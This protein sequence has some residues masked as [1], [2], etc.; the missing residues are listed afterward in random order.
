MHDLDWHRPDLD[1]F[2]R[3]SFLPP[4]RLLGAPRKPSA[5]SGFSFVQISDS[6]IGFNKP[7]NP[8]VTA[9]YWA[10][11]D[12]SMSDLKEFASLYRE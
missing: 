4:C 5:G 1:R 6:H 11:S 9:T 10:V 2:G 12:I 7:A 3:S 8:D